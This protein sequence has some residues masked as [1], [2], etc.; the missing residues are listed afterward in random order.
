M[1]KF[2]KFQALLIPI[3]VI[4]FILSVTLIF[5][6]ANNPS[7]ESS[8]STPNNQEENQSKSIKLSFENNTQIDVELALTIEEQSRGLMNRK[9]LDKHKGM[10]FIYQQ[11]QPLSF[12]MKNTYIPLDIIFLDKNKTILNIAENATPEQ[13]SPTFNSTGNAM[14]VVEVNGGFTKTNNI[15]VGSQVNFNDELRDD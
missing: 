15:K 1:P 3:T 2:K 14:Y 5:N 4:V 10:L 6:I 9:K 7:N 12:W 13:T 8:F 11:E